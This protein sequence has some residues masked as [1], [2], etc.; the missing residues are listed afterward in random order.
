M[1][2]TPQRFLTIAIIALPLVACRGE[3]DRAV[4]RKDLATA[5][6]EVREVAAE[7]KDRLGDGWITTKIQ[8]QY[9]ADD[10][11]HAR[12]ISV[13]TRDGRVTLRGYVE[14]QA[15]LEHVASVAAHTDGVRAVDNQIKIGQAPADAI[16]RARSTVTDTAIAT[17]GRVE[18]AAERAVE[19][20][21]P[22]ID[23]ARITTTIQARYFLDDRVKARRIAV[24]AHAGVVTVRGAVGSEDERAQALR[25]ARETEGVTRVEDA[26]TVDAAVN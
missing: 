18:E 11:I 5:S 2:P 6:A 1:M 20:A 3:A 23:D 8:A 22:L 25:I 26:L 9:F 13:G 17:S 10:E 15:V 7:A 14:N 12:Y 4:V 19:R 24:E 16:D 21:A